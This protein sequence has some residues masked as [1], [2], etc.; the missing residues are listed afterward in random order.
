VGH[1][2]DGTSWPEDGEMF[3]GSKLLSSQSTRWRGSSVN[4]PDS[5]PV[6]GPTVAD[7]IRR[8]ISLGSRAEHEQSGVGNEAIAQSREQGAYHLA[9]PH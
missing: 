2:R 5:I 4:C 3:Q 9:A 1:S 6:H 8:R 7:I